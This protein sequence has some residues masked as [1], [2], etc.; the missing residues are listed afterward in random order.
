MRT[1]MELS[2]KAVQ[3]FV[4]HSLD[5]RFFEELKLSGQLNLRFPSPTASLNLSNR[6]R[7]FKSLI[8]SN[9]K[10]VSKFA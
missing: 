6:L 8:E 5:H 4:T 3:D 9:T 10:D 7:P 2:I 1:T